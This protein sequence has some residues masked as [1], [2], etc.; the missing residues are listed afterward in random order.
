MTLGRSR[1]ATLIG[2][3]AVFALQLIFAPSLSLFGAMPNFVVAYVIVLS[4]A[5]PVPPATVLAFVMGM[6]YGLAVGGPVGGMALL[7]VLVAFLASRAFSVLAN[8]SLFMPIAILVASSLAVELLYAALLVLLG[9]DV[10]L[11]DTF[12]RRALPCALYDSVAGLVLYLVVIKF[13]VGSS[14]PRES[15]ETTNLR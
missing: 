4:I 8:D 6:L 15:L 1:V 11:F 3:V 2:A 5:R 7:L 14:A 13:V 10:G 12:V 9:L